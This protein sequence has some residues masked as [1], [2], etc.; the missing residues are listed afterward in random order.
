[1]ADR[2]WN[3]DVGTTGRH[4]GRQIENALVGWQTGRQLAVRR[5]FPT[6]TGAPCD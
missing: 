6:G 5:A 2:S 4:V 1:M 3:C